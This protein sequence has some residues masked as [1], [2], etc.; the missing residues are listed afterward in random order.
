MASERET[1]TLTR[2]F[3]GRLYILIVEVGQFTF[4]C[5]AR[6]WYSQRLIIMH[7]L[8][9]AAVSMRQDQPE[10]PPCATL[11]PDLASVATHYGS[12]LVNFM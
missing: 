1:A 6:L 9:L 8:M 11:T 5:V 7:F 4:K 2:I 3:H 10:T 12:E